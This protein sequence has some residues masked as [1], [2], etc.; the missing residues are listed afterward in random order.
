LQYP[1][2]NGD[3]LKE[4]ICDQAGPDH[5]RLQVPNFKRLDINEGYRG[6]EIRTTFDDTLSASKLLS[7]R[8]K[9]MVPAMQILITAIGTR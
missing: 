3:G 2:D 8:S 1:L 7:L 5:H 9:T 4:E 6:F